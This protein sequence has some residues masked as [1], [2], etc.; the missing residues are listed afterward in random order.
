MNW[1]ITAGEFVF[2]MFIITWWSY[3]LHVIKEYIRHKLAG[4]S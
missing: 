3:G 2:I 4:R 1:N